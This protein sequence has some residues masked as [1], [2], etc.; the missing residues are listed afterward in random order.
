MGG[1]YATLNGFINKLK[2]K[3]LVVAE[4]IPFSPVVTDNPPELRVQ[5]TS[6]RVDMRRVNCFVQGENSCRVD[7]VGGEKGWYRVVAE[8]PLTGRRNKY[9]LT[10]QGKKGGWYWYSHL[11]VNAKSPAIKPTGNAE[12]LS[13]GS[14][15][16]SSEAGEPVAADQ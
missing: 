1:P 12:I 7:V 16:D 13:A 5:I 11:W 9:T 2:M 4:E 14:E 3:P 8:K 10:V 6:D 15:A